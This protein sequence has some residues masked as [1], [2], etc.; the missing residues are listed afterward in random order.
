[1]FFSPHRN[2]MQLTVSFFQ[3]GLL[4]K[5]LI[6]GLAF[7]EGFTSHKASAFLYSRITVS[8]SRNEEP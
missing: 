2:Y 6:I 5:V 1:M 3:T 4:L 7:G 8:Q